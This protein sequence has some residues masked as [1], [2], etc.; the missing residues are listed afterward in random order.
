MLLLLHGEAGGWDELLIAVVAFAV[1]W[2]AVKLA[3]RK[4]AEEESDETEP[5][6]AETAPVADDKAMSASGEARASNSVADGTHSTHTEQTHEDKAHGAR[7]EQTR[8]GG[9]IGS[10]RP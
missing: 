3:G 5:A 6:A 10:E 1:M 9:G 4:P 8:T 2:L 7:E